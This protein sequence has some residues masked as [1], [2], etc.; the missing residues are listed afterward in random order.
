M[1]KGIPKSFG[2]GKT[3]DLWL[4]EYKTIEKNQMFHISVFV[5]HF[6]HKNVVNISTLLTSSF[7]Q[8]TYRVSVS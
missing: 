7:Y 6:I 8:L 3:I 2:D 5:L 4:T 1:K